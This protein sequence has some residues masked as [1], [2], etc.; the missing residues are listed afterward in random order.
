[1]Y[2]GGRGGEVREEK[3]RRKGDKRRKWAKRWRKGRNGTDEGEENG[4]RRVLSAKEQREDLNEDLF[5]A[6]AAKRCI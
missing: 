1:M 3:G 2:I 6:K 4:D 5:I